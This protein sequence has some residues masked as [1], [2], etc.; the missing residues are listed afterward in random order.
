MEDGLYI[1]KMSS[2]V[3]LIKWKQLG[4]FL[5]WMNLKLQTNR[6]Q[7][8]RCVSNKQNEDYVKKKTNYKNLRSIK[9]IITK[10][11]A[12]FQLNDLESNSEIFCWMFRII[13]KKHAKQITNNTL[14]IKI[15]MQ[16][17]WC[18]RYDIWYDLQGAYCIV[19]K[20]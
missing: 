19:V 17:D 6:Q 16:H 4:I 7:R 11:S 5:K 12:N 20:Y 8:K 10:I 18:K 14:N 3:L 13:H 2:F 9:H 1:I 15:T